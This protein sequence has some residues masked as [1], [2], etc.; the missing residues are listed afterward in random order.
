V[1]GVEECPKIR[2]VVVPAR[3]PGLGD[4]ITPRTKRA[5]VEVV[6]FK[7]LSVYFPFAAWNES[8]PCVDP[9]NGLAFE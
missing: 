2:A 1:P 4:Y 5:S 8:F 3:V 6:K 9:V 7:P